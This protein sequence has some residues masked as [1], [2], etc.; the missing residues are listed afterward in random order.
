MSDNQ[1]AILG[2][3]DDGRH[4]FFFDPSLVEFLHFC[5]GIGGVEDLDEFVPCGIA[6]GELFQVALQADAECLFSH[7]FFEFPHH[8]GCLVVDDVSVE[9]P[10]LVQILQLLLDGVGALGA[11]HGVSRDVVVLEEIQSMM[12]V[13]ELLLG[14]LRCHEVG[15]HFFGPHVGKPTHGDEVAKPHVRGFVSD[16]VEAHQ[17]F[18]RRGILAEEDFPVGKLNGTWM[19]HASELIARNH[20]KSVAVER[21]GNARVFLHPT[22]RKGDFIE[23]NWHLCHLLL[24]G[25]SVESTNDSSILL[26]RLFLK[27]SC[28]EGEKISW[29]RRIL[30]AAHGLPSFGHV[31]AEMKLCF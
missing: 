10:C 2:S 24:V 13:G 17:L 1:F 23:N 31:E 4:P 5:L 25:F 3:T 15:K 12:D 22:Q 18:I 11:V 21:V 8:H 30:H 26:C 29:D 16:E 6:E 14:N 28:Y 20:H 9:Q 7:L 19:L 27:L